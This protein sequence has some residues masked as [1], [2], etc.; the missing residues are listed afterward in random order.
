MKLRSI[1]Q[2]TPRPRAWLWPGRLALG[3][4]ALLEG[5]PGLGKSLLALDLCA[6]LSTGHPCPDGSPG[7]GT[8]TALV[9][10]AEDDNDNTVRSRLLALGA[11][12]GR[13]FVLDLEGDLDEPIRFPSG[14]AALDEV[15]ARTGARLVVIDPVLAF[16]D[17]DVNT[18]NDPSVRRALRPLARLAA[19][20]GCVIL[21]IL[22][23]NKN[24]RGKAAYRGLDSIAFLAVCRSAWL[25][26]ADPLL[27][28]RVVLAQVKNNRA[29]PQPSLAC[30]VVAA[31]GAAPTLAWHGPC[32]WTA[33]QLLAASPTAPPR[34]SQADRA[35]EF[36]AAFLAAGPR[37]SRELWAAAQEQGLAERTIERAK[38]DLGIRSVWV[39]TQGT[40]VSFW[41][42]PGQSLPP[43]VPPETAPPDLE[44]WLGPLRERFPP[45]TPLDDL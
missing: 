3:E 28:P 17:P 21:L 7:P 25:V 12:P 32:D 2:L 20:Y 22:H 6:R 23:L 19:K 35:R 42:L 45:S 30:E 38:H 9:L 37:T 5:D 36:L 29:A 4:L 27:P 24:G 11:D 8:G 16:L 31:G 15:L 10:N 40:P 13:V 34:L 18:A 41:L 14:A 39:T 44:K 33:N 26:A 1:D 43:A